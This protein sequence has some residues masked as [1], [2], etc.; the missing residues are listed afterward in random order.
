MTNLLASCFLYMTNTA[1]NETLASSLHSC[2]SPTD[3]TSNVSSTTMSVISNSLFYSTLVSAALYLYITKFNHTFRLGN[4]K[5]P[6]GSDLGTLDED[7]VRAIALASS[8][9]TAEL[10][11]ALLNQLQQGLS[12]NSREIEYLKA[13]IF[14]VAQNAKSDSRNLQGRLNRG[15]DVRRELEKLKEALGRLWHCIY[16]TSQ[17]QMGSQFDG[18]SFVNQVVANQ[19]SIDANSPSKCILTID[20]MKFDLTTEYGRNEWNDYLQSRHSGTR[21]D[22]IRT[23]LRNVSESDR[24][25]GE[26]IQQGKENASTLGLVQTEAPAHL[27]AIKSQ[28]QQLPAHKLT[29]DTTKPELSVNTTIESL[30]DAPRQAEPK[31]PNTAS[32]HD[33]STVISTAQIKLSSPV[34]AN[35]LKPSLSPSPLIISEN[36][37]SQNSNVQTTEN[38][39]VKRVSVK[40]VSVKNDGVPNTNL[41]APVASQSPYLKK[42]SYSIPKW[43]QN[44]NISSRNVQQKRHNTPAVA[45]NDKSA[46]VNLNQS[47]KPN[48][49]RKSWGDSPLPQPID[50]AS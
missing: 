31:T 32:A 48:S 40:S 8:A 1:S 3:A 47:A 28:G 24:N 50:G 20:G 5:I 23:P 19:P 36:A 44:S 27:N 15:G 39:E 2:F 21:S 16:Q 30:N 43:T 35:V 22:G 41:S 33:I 14:D 11:Q 26:A 38:K 42:G 25:I 37:K 46:N 34:Q 49:P 6:K 9:A 29:T 12:S 17:Q 7:H 10:S 13:K 45:S 4:T 18:Q